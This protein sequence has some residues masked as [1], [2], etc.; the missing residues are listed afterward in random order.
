M[1]VLI[2]WAGPPQTVRPMYHLVVP[3]VY[4]PT[5]R[6]PGARAPRPVSSLGRRWSAVVEPRCHSTIGDGELAPKP[7]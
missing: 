3:G 1:Y 6:L 4:T 7:L 2:L 5:P